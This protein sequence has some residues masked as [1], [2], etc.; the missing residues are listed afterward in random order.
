MT[1]PAFISQV[2]ILDKDNQH[3]NPELSQA[4]AIA[5]PTANWGWSL[6]VDGAN[7][8][9]SSNSNVQFI[10]WFRVTQTMLEEHYKSGFLPRPVEISTGDDYPYEMTTIFLMH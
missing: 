7:A 4:L 9:K 3:V 1:D 2:L 5:L 10:Y 8:K 6:N